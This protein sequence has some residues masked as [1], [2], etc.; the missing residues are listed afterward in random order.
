[1]DEKHRGA[2]RAHDLLERPDR[3]IGLILLGNNLVNFAAA[4]LA[5]VIAIR[6]YGE[7]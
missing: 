5:T 4:S 2:T 1:V 6:L 7:I 3:L